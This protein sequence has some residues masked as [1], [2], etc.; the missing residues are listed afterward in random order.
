MAPSLPSPTFL[1]LTDSALGMDKGVGSVKLPDVLHAVRSGQ[2]PLN[3]AEVNPENG[4]NLLHTAVRHVDRFMDDH[5]KG[6]VLLA[7]DLGVDLSAPG[8]DGQTALQW[9]HAHKKWEVAVFLE[10]QGVSLGQDELSA[11]LKEA[12]QTLSGWLSSRSYL[13]ASSCILSTLSATRSKSLDERTPRQVP[14]GL[15]PVWNKLKVNAASLTSVGAGPGK[16]LQELDSSFKALRDLGIEAV[17]QDPTSHFGLWCWASM[18]QAQRWVPH[19]A[20]Q[21]RKSTYESQWKGLE[22]ALL[23][24]YGKQGQPELQMVDDFSTEALKTVTDLLEF[25]QKKGPP[26]ANFPDKTRQKIA[27]L[28]TFS[29][30]ALSSWARRLDAEQPEL[31]KDVRQGAWQLLS[32]LTRALPSD[33]FEVDVVRDWRSGMYYAL[34]DDAMQSALRNQGEMP[35]FVVRPWL[36][37]PNVLIPQDEGQKLDVATQWLMSQPPGED[38]EKARLLLE[39]VPALRAHLEASRLENQLEADTAP[40]PRRV[41]RL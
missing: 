8:P 39:P 13:G 38:L 28:C 29:V 36:T 11:E 34:R 12:H 40:S 17:K 23:R 35:A 7:K 6:L 37:L 3:P 4:W 9:A 31:A 30:S 22:K 1:I 27:W 16:E 41:P 2:W 20:S 15:L 25:H 5:W 32:D 14:L 33:F 26:S 21:N 18:A 10:K 24:R 19:D